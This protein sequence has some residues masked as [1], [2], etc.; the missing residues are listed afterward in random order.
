MIEG[1]TVA[2]AHSLECFELC[3]GSVCSVFASEGHNLF[4]TNGLSLRFAF[5]VT[6]WELA[7]IQPSRNYSEGSLRVGE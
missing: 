1:K 5:A 4:E 3:Q 6:A 2:Q 7:E